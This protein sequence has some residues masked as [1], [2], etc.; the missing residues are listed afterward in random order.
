MVLRN[1]QIPL[2]APLLLVVIIL[3]LFSVSTQAQPPAKRVSRF[4][5]NRDVQPIAVSPSPVQSQVAQA[6]A[7]IG[8]SFGMIDF[9]RSPDSTAFGVNSKGDIV[10]IYGPNLPVWEGETQSY[11]LEGDTFHKIGFPGAP[12][13][14]AFGINKKREIVGWY[15]DS[16]GN[17]AWHAF[18]KKG[19]NYTNIDYPGADNTAAININDAGEI[20][21]IYFQNSGGFVHAFALSKGVYTTIN[22]PLAYDI[23]P[24]GINSNGVVVGTYLDAENDCHGFVFQ[25][26]QV[27]TVD[28]PGAT[29]TIL[30]GINDAGQIVG[31]FGG[32]VL[33][34]GLDWEAP[35][36][37][38]LNQGTF[39]PLI[40]PA[41]DA[42]V[43]WSYALN[44][45]QL[46][47]FYV[48]SLGN[49]QGYTATITQ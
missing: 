33:I 2:N 34:N 31:E 16:S 45:N 49:I 27:T 4:G 47:G 23:D 13:T 6:L 40:L 18:L 12:Y 20:I 39:T 32:N 11:F 43:T 48:D 1:R 22:S 38:L 5:G 15:Y 42:Q 14:S 44:G 41:A 10:G 28:Y 9:P 19:Q 46:V 7:G 17:G 8:L 25:N 37:F 30:T 21:G 24:G 3:G 36:I 35:N 26:G 29:N